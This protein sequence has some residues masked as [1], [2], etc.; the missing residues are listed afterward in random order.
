[1]ITLVL[2]PSGSGKTQWL[3]TEANKE[4]AAG[5]GNIVFIDSDDS[6]I[7][8]L[9]YSVRLIDAHQFKIDNFDSL[10]GFLSGILSRDYDIKKMYIDGIYDLFDVDA[11]L[12]R[13]LALLEQISTMNKVDIYLGLD[14]KKADIPESFAAELVELGD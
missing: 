13:L 10:Y 3:I 4:V 11:D 8:T 14:L 2:G 1:M 5:N 9:D 6:H 7:F 12:P